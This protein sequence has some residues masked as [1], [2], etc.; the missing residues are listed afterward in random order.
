METQRPGAAMTIR[1]IT[2][3]INDPNGGQFQE[4]FWSINGTVRET[5]ATPRWVVPAR[6]MP[7]I[8]AGQTV[9]LAARFED[10]LGWTV[11]LTTARDFA[12]PR[13]LAVEIHG[14]TTFA[15]G[16]TYTAVLAPAPGRS[17]RTTTAQPAVN[18]Q[19]GFVPNET[20]RPPN[21]AGSIMVEPG[22]QPF[23]PIHGATNAVYT[24]RASE[25]TGQGKLRV[26]VQQ[27]AAPGVM[28]GTQ[29]SLVGVNS[30][31]TGTA[32]VQVTAVLPGAV[33]AV[34]STLQD[35]NGLVATLWIWESSTEPTFRAP[36]R[37][38]GGA[39]GRYTLRPGE[40]TGVEYL[41]ARIG[42]RDSA[43]A[44]TWITTSPQRINYPPE[45]QLKLRGYSGAG[46]ADNLV[47]G[48]VRVNRP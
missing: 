38:P 12:Q 14:P 25:L 20:R 48:F 23:A 41:R 6:L 13:E 9:A 44:T 8:A 17:R 36:A 15:P 35:I 27:T 39:A 30:P 31:A 45:G 21:A 47:C 7:G 40:L 33:V 3:G 22:A 42:G 26:L 18:Y 43:G 19:W 11:T 4:Y 16:N 29:A 24:M 46:W 37:L 10:E 28:I 2:L 5:T 32:E 34:R 1:A